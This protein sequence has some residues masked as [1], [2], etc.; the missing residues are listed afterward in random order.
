VIAGARFRIFE[1]A[2]TFEPL[3]TGHPPHPLASACV[4][5]GEAWSQLAPV[6][7]P[8]STK[9]QFKMFSFH[10][11]EELDASG[12]VGWLASH[13][14]RTVGTGVIV[15]GGKDW[16]GGEALYAASRGVFDCW[17]CPVG[18]GDAVIAEIHW[19]I[20]QG[21]ASPA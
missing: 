4:R 16:R 12:F 15:I 1:G 3:S 21:R 2:Y 11:N 18:R 5:D 14:K 7:S 17:G 9:E 13:L 6:S 19:L 8:H 20:D 10:F